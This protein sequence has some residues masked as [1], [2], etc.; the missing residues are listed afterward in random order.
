MCVEC[1]GEEDMIIVLH[2]VEYL[3]VRI[4]KKGFSLQ[5]STHASQ[6]AHPFELGLSDTT[7]AWS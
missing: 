4:S 7:F 6:A 5:T 3:I 1:P 2:I